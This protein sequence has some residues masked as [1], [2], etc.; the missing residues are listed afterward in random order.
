MR[1]TRDPVFGL[2][3]PVIVTLCGFKLYKYILLSI[4]KNGAI[5]QSFWNYGPLFSKKT[6]FVPA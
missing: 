1:D 4:Y 3:G 5:H 6:L 2:R